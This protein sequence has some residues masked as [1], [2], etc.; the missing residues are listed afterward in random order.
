MNIIIAGGGE[1]GYQLARELHINYDITVIDIDE[2]AFDRFSKLDINFVLGNG[3]NAQVLSSANIE[4]ADIFIACTP[5]DE[6]NIISCWTAK[7]MSK[8]E[9]ICFVNHHE[10]IEAFQ[11]KENMLIT[12][13][14]FGLDQII[15]PKKSLADELEKIISV[16]AAI[17]VEIFASGKVKLF[18]YR[19]KSTTTNINMALKD[20]DF[21]ENCIIVAIIR[22]DEL[23]I[24]D[25]NTQL[26][27]NDKVIF[28]GTDEALGILS[29][30]FFEIKQEVRNVT[31][32][33]GGTV[34][35][36]LAKSLSQKGLH[37]IIIEH[38]QKICD[39]LKTQLENTLILQGD[40]TDLELLQT[41][42]I[43]K[44]DVL[45]TVTNNDEK[46]LLC[47]LLG[48]QLG[49][50]KVLT[51]VD[52]TANLKLFELVGIDVALSPKSSSVKELLNSLLES[53]ID[54]L[55]IVERGKGE[56]FEITVANSFE[57]TQVKDLNFP[58]KAIIG[59]VIRRKK[60]II[61]KGNT[62]IRPG[63][64]LIIFTTPTAANKVKDFFEKTEE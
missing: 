46:N 54:L 53:D 8:V 22:N 17:D 30:R 25:G 19:V 51:R 27:E 58:F 55:A 36:M 50:K 16:P 32:I 39:A 20:C 33:G 56:V 31:I 43:G 42:Q 60:V 38:S 26:L 23:F 59:T 48:K 52:K 64:R 40:G 1:F 44:T 61:P 57:D 9:T 41:E 6:V 45:V 15:W 3:A 29:S 62:L 37:T 11:N 63:D 47:S 18:E 49:V 14:Q 24:P 28:I 35:F 34:G 10:Y 7:H 2:K 21:P 12:N 4:T 13:S 5:A